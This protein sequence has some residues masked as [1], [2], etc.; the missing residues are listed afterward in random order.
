MI[1][2]IFIAAALATMLPG[3]ASAAVEQFKFSGPM[4]SGSINGHAVLDVEGGL[5]TSGS[6]VISG[7]GISGLQKLYLVTPAGAVYRSA[8]GTDLFGADNHYPI[9]NGGLAF[10][11][12]AP[13][14]SFGGYN[15]GI[16]TNSP[17]AYEGFV[18]GP[19]LWS[20]TGEL[21]VQPAPEISTIAMLAL[22]VGILVFAGRR[23][24]RLVVASA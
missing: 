20:Y 7:W 16:W 12:Y 1:K 21:T 14:V 17:D 9:D 13:G 10:G 15:F 24:A 4:G 19:G 18:S 22:G 2:P 8:N 6:V 11:A 5:A 3:A 23:Q